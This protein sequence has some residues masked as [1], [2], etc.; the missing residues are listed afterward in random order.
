MRKPMNLPDGELVRRYGEGDSVTVLAQEYG[1]SPATISRR[2]RALGVAM[3]PN[4]YQPLPI[5]AEEL[6]R[7]YTRERMPL[8]MIARR[9]RVS[10]GTVANRR[11]AFRIPKRGKEQP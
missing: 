6:E 1:C 11:R 4:R 9:L 2:L 7:L 3:R 10:V 5:A 8:K